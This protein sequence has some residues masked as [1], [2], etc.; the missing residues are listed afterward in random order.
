M[1]P[2]NYVK[3]KKP[4]K[5]VEKFRV[6]Q[7]QQ[8]L[9]ELG[10]ELIKEPEIKLYYEEFQKFMKWEH[11]LDFKIEAFHAKREGRN[12]WATVQMPQRLG[13]PYVLEVDITASKIRKNDYKSLLF[14]E[15]THIYDELTIHENIKKQGVAKPGTWY[16]EAHATE[17][18]LMCSCGIDS[19]FDD[20]KVE[21]SSKIPYYSEE[22]TIADFGSR[23]EKEIE[24]RIR[25]KDYVGAIKHLQYY[26]GYLKFLEK[27]C[28]DSKSEIDKG[29]IFI[30]TNF[31]L[32]ALLIKDI[33]FKKVITVTNFNRINNLS[34][35]VIHNVIKHQKK[36]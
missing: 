21:V 32:E 10:M 34:R 13:D 26:I 1:P 20:R 25:E 14:H 12:S 9:H 17:V 22:I 19:Y 28:N 3:Q 30:Y 15:F 31:G 6:F 35:I 23:K 24:Y 36:I 2:K 7:A 5:V 27:H 8:K 33:I 11:P 4:N 18:E 29:I 16:T